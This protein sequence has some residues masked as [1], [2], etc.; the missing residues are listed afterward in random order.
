VKKAIKKLLSSS[1]VGLII[2]NAEPSN[3]YAS[4]PEITKPPLVQSKLNGN[5]LIF[6]VPPGHT[7]EW[8]YDGDAQRKNSVKIRDKDSG[9]LVYEDHNKSAPKVHRVN[10]S[11]NESARVF[12][13]TFFGADAHCLTEE[14][15]DTLIVRFEDG[16]KNPVRTSKCNDGNIY[17]LL[18]PSDAADDMQCVDLG[19]RRLINKNKKKDTGETTKVVIKRTNAHANRH[20]AH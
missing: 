14:R 11:P 18:Y 16:G 8:F 6:T 12:E 1:V 9:L 17:C 2:L 20:C 5:K 4:Q 13:A 3:T 7:V 19:G 15:F 10:V